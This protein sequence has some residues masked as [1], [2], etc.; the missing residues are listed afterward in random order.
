M[1]HDLTLKNFTN[2]CIGK[3]LCIHYVILTA[4]TIRLHRILLN[5]MKLASKP[6][7]TVFRPGITQR[8]YSDYSSFTSKAT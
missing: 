3:F 1:Q 5:D 7:V 6:C 4:C 2:R 8:F